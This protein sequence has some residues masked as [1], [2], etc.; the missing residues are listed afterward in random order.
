V[1]VQTPPCPAD[2]DRSGA[3]DG[4]DLAT[5]LGQWGVA[6]SADLDGSG[7]VD[8]SDLAV[9]LNAWGACPAS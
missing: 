5:L 7:M 6:G 9:L 1:I 4:A 3:V 2:I 8:G